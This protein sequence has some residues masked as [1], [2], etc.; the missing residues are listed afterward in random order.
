MKHTYITPTSQS[1][2]FQVEAPLLS[3]SSYEVSSPKQTDVLLS[4]EKQWNDGG[5]W[6]NHADE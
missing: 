2:K 4:N 5:I 1:V 6:S 3:N